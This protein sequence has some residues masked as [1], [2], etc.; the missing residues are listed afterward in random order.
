LSISRHIPVHSIASGKR[1]QASMPRTHLGKRLK[2]VAAGSAALMAALPGIAYPQVAFFDPQEGVNTVFLGVGSAPDY[3]GSADNQAAIAPLGRYYFSGK[4]YVQ[5]L[6]P[7]ISLNLA[8]D[9]VWQFGPQVLFR[10]KRDSDVD[11]PVVA[12]MRPIDS[13]VEGGVFVAASWKLGSDPRHRFGVRADI[14]AGSNGTEGT[15][16]ANYYHPVSRGVVLNLGGGM[17]FSNDKWAR[18]YYGVNGTDVALFPS[19]GG[20][21]YNAQGGVNDFRVNF[22]AIVHLSPQWHLALGARY[23]RLRGDAV[24]SPIVSQRGDRDQWI[25][26]AGI[27]YVWQ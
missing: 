14:Q 6:G 24:D 15:L 27:G 1:E 4:R 21:E 23:L 26:G 17:G 19:L 8:N 25:Y 13:E 22:G 3:M 2:W 18:T 11:D 12:R 7:Q 16:T 10:F 5:L 9:E 20:N